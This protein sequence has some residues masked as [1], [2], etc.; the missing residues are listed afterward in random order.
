MDKR[1]A[2]RVPVRLRAQCR[3]DDVVIDGM[4]EDISRSGVFFR[5]PKAM[6]AKAI[7]AGVSTEI[8][9]NLPGETMLQLTAK[10]VR[11]DEAGMGLVFVG[12]HEHS[13]KPLANFIMRCHAT[14]WNWS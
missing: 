12:G 1:E 9:L 11:V 10:V 8:H 13:R 4:V 6:E 5:A 2:V 7:E 3:A 14:H